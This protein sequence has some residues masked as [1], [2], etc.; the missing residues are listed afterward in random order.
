M[1]MFYI[2]LY[3]H[4]GVLCSFL[5]SACLVCL[6]VCLFAYLADLDIAAQPQSPTLSCPLPTSL[7]SCLHYPKGSHKI[8]Y[9]GW[10]GTA[11]PSVLF[12]PS[13][14]LFRAHRK[15][16]RKKLHNF[17]VCAIISHPVSS[18]QNKNPEIAQMCKVENVLKYR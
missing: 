5:I 10:L 15:S 14:V 7:L 6:S 17:S 16:F 11:H 2:S 8:S 9:A 13:E 3:Q 12:S 18:F 4:W 1:C